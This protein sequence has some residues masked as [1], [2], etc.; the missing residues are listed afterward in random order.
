ME[1]EKISSFKTRS[2]QNKL[3]TYLLVCSLETKIKIRLLKPILI[4]LKKF[5]NSILTFFLPQNILVDYSSKSVLLAK[6]Y[7]QKSNHRLLKETV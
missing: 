4:D 1:R 3:I 6:K 7:N 2:P 5:S